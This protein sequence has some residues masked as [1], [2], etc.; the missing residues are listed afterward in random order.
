MAEKWFHRQLLILW[1]GIAATRVVLQFGSS[2][3]FINPVGLDLAY[4]VFTL[5]VIGREVVILK[6][7]AQL[8]GELYESPRTSAVFSSARTVKSRIRNLKFLIGLMMFCL[9][10]GPWEFRHERDSMVP[11]I[12]GTAMNLLFTYF[13]AVALFRLK[14]ESNFSMAKQQ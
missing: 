2:L 1:I 4:A 9:P 5:T 14:N 12:I 11:F 13:W 3:G 8:F 7:A 10:F 6:R